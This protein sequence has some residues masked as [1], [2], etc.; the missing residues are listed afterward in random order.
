MPL[1]G[2]LCVFENKS[3]ADRA[4]QIFSVKVASDFPEG[5]ILGSIS[6]HGTWLLRNGGNFSLSKVRTSIENG[7][8]PQVPQDSR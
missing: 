4:A 7:V 8:E 6:K 5:C 3:Q 2:I 1:G